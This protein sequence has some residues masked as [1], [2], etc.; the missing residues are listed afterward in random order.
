MGMSLVAEFRTALISDVYQ[1]IGQWLNTEFNAKLTEREAARISRGEDTVWQLL[2]DQ[3]SHFLP[4][5]VSSWKEYE[6]AIFDQIITPWLAEN[7]TLSTRAEW[8][9]VNGVTISHPLSAALPSVLRNFLDMERL[10]LNGA[11]NMPLVQYGSLGASEHIIVTPSA[12]SQ[13]LY[14]MPGG[15]SGNPF[16]PF[17][18]IGHTAWASA[19]PLPILSTGTDYQFTIQPK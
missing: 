5:G 9:S 16:S 10:P 8:G 15:Q 17:Y 4:Y 7:D 1:R 13:G 14:N 3:P 6:L 12:E 19:Q 18:R 11:T 2:Q